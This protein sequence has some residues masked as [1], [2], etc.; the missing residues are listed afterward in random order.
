M[1]YAIR[2]GLAAVVLGA[3][4]PAAVP[5][6]G[7]R[8]TWQVPCEVPEDCHVGHGCGPHDEAWA[9][10]PHERFDD[11]GSAQLARESLA[12]FDGSSESSR[13][14]NESARLELVYPSGALEVTARCLAGPAVPSWEEQLRTWFE[15]L[16]PGGSGCDESSAEFYAWEVDFGD[17]G[18]V[19]S[20]ADTDAAAVER[21]RALFESAGSTAPFQEPS[22]S[23][24]RAVRRSS[25]QMDVYVVDAAD[26]AELDGLPL[27]L[28]QKVAR[29]GQ[30]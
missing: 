22:F 9:V 27:Q 24:I 11:L 23:L 29:S 15:L 18:S 12:W 2:L 10:G 14:G 8:A 13:R 5:E 30:D 20:H 17:R 25:H 4:A 26:S 1:Q 16:P 19:R 28:R 6:F 7:F 21:M 3:C